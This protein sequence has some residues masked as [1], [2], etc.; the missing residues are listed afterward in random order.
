MG[1]RKLAGDMVE[2][3]YISGC[4]HLID[5]GLYSRQNYLS[6]W[7]CCWYIL[8]FVVSFIFFVSYFIESEFLNKSEE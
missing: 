5:K 6:C 4:E 7:C 2:R 3:T 8:L 1:G